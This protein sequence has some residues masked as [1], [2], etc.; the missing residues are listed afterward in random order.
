[1]PEDERSE[2]GRSPG[3]PAPPAPVGTP[4][5]AAAPSSNG[6]AT[7]ALVLGIL[8]IVFFWTVWL[9]VILGILATVFGATARSRVRRG[10]PHFASATAGFIL[11]VVG[12]ACSLLFLAIVLPTTRVASDH[13][14]PRR[15]VV[16][17]ERTAVLHDRSATT[18]PPR[19]RAVAGHR[20]S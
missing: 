13:A 4:T 2:R 9:G 3:L 18:E 7:A 15:A 10:D 16:A 8:A 6:L 20:C 17:V 19:H 5:V 11:G 14:L 1:M 12:L